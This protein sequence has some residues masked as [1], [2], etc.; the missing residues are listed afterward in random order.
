MS[1]N[2]LPSLGSK[3]D[4]LIKS[5]NIDELMDDSKDNSVSDELM[6]GFLFQD[7]Q[8]LCLIKNLNFRSSNL[9]YF[10]L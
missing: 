7:Y 4:D 5:D 8:P 3:I 10:R 2:I 6:D 9:S 1:M